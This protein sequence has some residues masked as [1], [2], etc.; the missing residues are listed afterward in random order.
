MAKAV[1]RLDE[2]QLRGLVEEGKGDWG[3]A[4][5]R[6]RVGVLKAVVERCKDVGGGVGKDVVEA[7]KNAFEIKTEADQALLVPCILT[8]KTVNVSTVS[9]LSSFC[10]KEPTGLT[11]CL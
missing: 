4:V 10:R 2:P 6:A 9:F 11:P 5:K 1:T 8:L 7:I 3:R